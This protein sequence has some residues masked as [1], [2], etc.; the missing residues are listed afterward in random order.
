[1]TPFS[2]YHGAPSSYYHATPLHAPAVFS[3]ALIV[4][5]LLALTLTAV[6][7]A[8]VARRRHAIPQA[9]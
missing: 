5:I 2:Y 8:V 4:A 7:P 3:P 9:D 1:M 6:V